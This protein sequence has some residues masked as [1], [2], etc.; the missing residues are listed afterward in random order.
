MASSSAPHPGTAPHR[1]MR[2][3]MQACQPSVRTPPV[4]QSATTP[5]RQTRIMAAAPR[6]HA[7]A[8]RPVIRLP[9]ICAA[10]GPRTA[11]LT[12]VQD[13]ARLL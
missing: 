5:S 10:L 1:H 2:T 4:R 6:A 7:K 11:R 12:L 9:A 13:C 3:H 8:A